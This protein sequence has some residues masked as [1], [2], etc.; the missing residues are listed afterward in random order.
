[1]ATKS[2]K[3]CKSIVIEKYLSK[4]KQFKLYIPYKFSIDSDVCLTRFELKVTARTR[5]LRDSVKE[6]MLTRSSM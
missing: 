6:I 5:Y 1:M 4:R 3:E 2:R